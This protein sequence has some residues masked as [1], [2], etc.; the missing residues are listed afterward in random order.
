VRAL[1]LHERVLE[2]HHGDGH[3][4]PRHP[5][6]P[7]GSLR[8]RHADPDDLLRGA[9]P[10]RPTVPAIA[11]LLLA[12][13]AAA[14]APCP[15]VRVV[16]PLTERGTLA[17]A[18]AAIDVDFGFPP[19]QDTTVV[20]GP[21]EAMF[22]SQV[23]VA[24]NRLTYLSDL[25]ADPS[26]VGPDAG[27]NPGPGA[28]FSLDTSGSLA[29]VSDGTLCGPS[30]T[31][32]PASGV[33]VDPIGIAWNE[34]RSLLVI[35]D[36]DADPSGLG[37]DANGHAGH[38]AV[39]AIDPATGQVDVVADGRDY[40]AGIPGGAPSIFEDP[41]AI[42]FGWDGS[43]FVLD[44]LAHPSGADPG[45]VFG[46]DPLAG[47]VTLVS[48]DPALRGPRDLAVEPGG[49]ILVLDRIE[50]AI[51]RIDPGLPPGSN[52]VA[53]L[54]P[55][56]LVDPQGIVVTGS[57]GILV[58]DGAADP[59][60]DAG[61][62][63]HGALFSVDPVSGASVPVSSTGDY[64]EPW[65]L[66]LL[67]PYALDGA[68]PPR[69][70]PGTSLTVQL[71]GGPWPAGVVPDFGPGITV[72]A[73]RLISPAMLEADITIDAGAALGLRDVSIV[74]PGQWVMAFHCELFEV[75]AFTGC[76][77]V[78]GIGE[79]LSVR[80]DGPA[81][82]LSWEAPADACRSAFRV[83]R[84]PTARPA[85]EPGSWPGDPPFADVSAQDA[86]GDDTNGAFVEAPAAGDEYFLVVP[87]GT[88]GTEGAS[89]SYG[90]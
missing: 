69:G 78:A 88:D 43:L 31:N 10:V 39:L 26:H 46:V 59:F 21:A 11:A 44:Q 8:T 40:P 29:V 61:S 67:E 41:I 2:R 77:P 32:C 80:K 18:G 19:T 36:P 42:A 55:A 24:R 45:A 14:S 75:H 34:G 51:H 5:E 4:L 70:A 22:L 62:V 25:E 65:G 60:G 53:T 82:A 49:T 15:G 73:T 63:F 54:L 6:R 81:I 57:G 1:P 68:S 33:F 23:A 9:V 3:V 13:S 85:S 48:S 52:V 35:V 76:A 89:G 83:R 74:G 86:D 79:S 56:G 28:V 64:E 50:R 47:T 12:G 66:D 90:G 37:P 58:A 84:S 7:A 71:S 38:G 30:I 72:D 87:I 20:G 17:P 27:G 16:D